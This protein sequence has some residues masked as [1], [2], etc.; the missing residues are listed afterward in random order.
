MNAVDLHTREHYLFVA[1]GV[2][3][4]NKILVLDEDEPAVVKIDDQIDGIVDLHIDARCIRRSVLMQD[5][6]QDKVVAGPVVGVRHLL[7]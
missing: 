5:V 7:M 3:G 6:E 4:L 2:D 1:R